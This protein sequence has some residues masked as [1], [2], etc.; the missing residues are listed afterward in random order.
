MSKK[1]AAVLDAEREVFIYGD[2]EAGVP[3]CVKNGISEAI[4]KEI[5]EDMTD[6]AKYAFNKSHAAAYATVCYRTAWLLHYFPAE[7]FAA[8]MTRCV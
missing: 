5:F 2:E 3:G 6:F 4:A 8:L 7:Y 1:K